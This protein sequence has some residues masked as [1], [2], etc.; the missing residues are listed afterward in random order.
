MYLKTVV[1]GVAI[2]TLSTVAALAQVVA[3]DLTLS[4]AKIRAAPP[5]APVSAGFMVIANNGTEPERLLGGSVSFAGSVEVHEM[6]MENEVMRMRELESGLE[7]PPGG[8]VALRPGGYHI[9]FMQLKEPVTVGDSHT[10]T[11]LFENAGTVE[12]QMPVANV[13]RGGHADR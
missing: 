11:L 7:I 13:T 8:S 4:D 9:M 12:L 10:V 3:G 6:T 1:L 2:T 5:G